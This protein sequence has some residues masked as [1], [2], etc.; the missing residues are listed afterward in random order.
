MAPSLIELKSEVIPLEEASQYFSFGRNLTECLRTSLQLVFTRHTLDPLATSTSFPPRRSIGLLSSHFTRNDFLSPS[1]Q[2]KLLLALRYAKEQESTVYIPDSAPSANSILYACT[3]LE[4]PAYRVALESSLKPENPV[5]SDRHHTSDFVVAFCADEVLALSIKPGGTVANCLEL[6]L[7]AKEIPPHSVRIVVPNPITAKQKQLLL[8]FNGQGAVL[9]FSSHSNERIQEHETP[10]SIWA[11]SNRPTPHT[12]QPVGPIPASLYENTDYLIH[13]TRARQTGWPDQ[14]PTDLLDE[15]FRLAFNPSPSPLESLYRI[16]T[17]QRLIASNLH[18]RGT[19][20]TV[21]FTANTLAKLHTMR[22]F[23][24]HL[25]RWDWEPYGIAIPMHWLS[26]LGARPVM[27]LPTEQIRNL[28]EDEKCFA[29]PIPNGLKSELPSQHQTSTEKATR[30]SRDWGVEREWRL[31]GDLRF[32]MLN[33]QANAGTKR[34]SPFV[35]VR[36]K[37]EAQSI[38]DR[39]RWP[40]YWLEDIQKL[41]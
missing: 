18:R 25:A 11:C 13:C 21:C 28:P 6:R 15:A 5:K 35:F 20:S 30:T 19:R 1:W 29:Q 12:Q 27:Y 7:A 9:W 37:T 17:T 26:F 16:L 31:V 2:R 23:Q 41:T 38:A 8:K 34:L 36:R 33:N 3:Q 24:S 10:H 39:S 14:S 40:V 32:N 4:I 22:N